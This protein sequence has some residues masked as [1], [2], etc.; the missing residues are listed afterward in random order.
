[1]SAS[2]LKHLT[3][4]TMAGQHVVKGQCSASVVLTTDH[5]RLPVRL[6]TV[7]AIICPMLFISSVLHFWKIVLDQVKKTFHITGPILTYF[8]LQ[9][10]PMPSTPLK[11]FDTSF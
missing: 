1:M 9:C 10:I 8:G 11:H 6:F 7:V 3:W 5:H 2:S 4:E